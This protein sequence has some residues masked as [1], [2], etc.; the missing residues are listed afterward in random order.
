MNRVLAGARK[1]EFRFRCS[2]MTILDSTDLKIAFTSTPST[3]FSGDWISRTAK[4]GDIGAKM[5]VGR[6]NY[7][8]REPITGNARGIT[9]KSEMPL[10]HPENGRTR[11]TDFLENT[12]AD[13]RVVTGYSSPPSSEQQGNSIPTY[14]EQV[15]HHE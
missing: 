9:C 5:M 8:I 4:L 2:K 6:G 13:Y 1:G 7:I 10:F 15:V 3:R 12:E 11:A 14:A